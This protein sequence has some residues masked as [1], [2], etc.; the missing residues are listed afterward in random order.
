MKTNKIIEVCIWVLVLI[1]LIS[2]MFYFTNGLHWISYKKP[3]ANRRTQGLNEAKKEIADVSNI[4][5]IE[6]RLRDADVVINAVEGNEIEVIEYAKDNDENELFKMTKEGSTLKFE[7]EY[8]EHFG[9]FFGDDRVQHYIEVKLPKDFSKH[10]V[11]E[12][13]SGDVALVDAFIFDEL[14]LETTSGN[15]SI[16]EIEAECEIGATSGDIYIEKIHGSEHHIG[17]T[18]GNMTLEEIKGN[19]E[20]GTTS[21]DIFIRMIEGKEHEIGCTSGK[22][23]IEEGKGDFKIETTSGDVFLK[24]VSGSKHEIST[25]SGDIDIQEGKGEF[26]TET[27]SGNIRKEHINE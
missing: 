1:S 22:V 6:L 11:I 24:K 19:L 8:K 18:S 3:V 21:G 26:D 25:T 20:A 7:R 15:I 4:D 14:E 9:F 12:N 17:A 23:T 13:S 10:L 2:G 5:Q 16:H 27:N